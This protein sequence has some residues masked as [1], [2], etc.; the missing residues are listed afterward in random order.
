[1]H[2]IITKFTP[3]AQN[4][5]KKLYFLNFKLAKYKKFSNLKSIFNLKKITVRYKYILY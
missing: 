2:K 4:R 5:R 3:Y 1:M